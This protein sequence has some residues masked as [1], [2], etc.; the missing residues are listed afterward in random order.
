[1]KRSRLLYAGLLVAALAAWWTGD[2]LLG[3]SD[4]PSDP[5]GSARHR[6]M[7]PLT[8]ALADARARSAT[9]SWK[10][11]P[12]LDGGVTIS[13]AVIDARTHTGVGGVEV[14]FRSEAGEE[15]TTA[16]EDGAYRIDLPI[17]TYRAFVRDDTVLSIGRPDHVRLPGLPSADTAGVPDEA[18]MP[19]VVANADVEG[20]DLTVTRGGVVRGKVVDAAGRAIA[21]A[22]LRARTPGFRPALGTD[23][24][25]T[26][27]DGAFELRLPAGSYHLEVGHPRF[28]GVEGEEERLMI[29]PGDVVTRTF[30]LIAG[31]VIAGRV[32]GADGRATGDGAIEKQWGSSDI[33]FS[34]S[35]RIAPD[36]TFRWTTTEEI[37]VVLRAWPWK[38]P[39][40][41]SQ[42]FSCRDGARYD[43]VV[44]ALPNRGPDLDGVLVDRAGAPV[45]MAF[46]DLMPLDEG[47]IA[48]QER[49]DAQGRWSVFQLPAGRYR[50]MAHAPARGIVAT[51]IASPQTQVRLQLGGTGRI[52]GTASRL[53]K[54]SFELAFAVC[55]DDSGPIRLPV[56]RRLVTVTGG[57]FVVD[58]VPACDLQYVASWRGRPRPGRIEVAAGGTARIELD[59]GPPRAKVVHGTV[60]DAGRPVEGATV[61]AVHEDGPPVTA[62]TDAAGRYTLRTSL[63]ARIAAIK[64]N[65]SDG[66][67]RHGYAVAA[68]E[69][70]EPVDIAFTVTSSDGD[71]FEGPE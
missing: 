42:S 53:A 9:L 12:R 66:Q 37:E 14:V 39:P 29:E 49:T 20:V 32:V 7:S 15:T 44:F 1:M 6:S 41:P 10:P 71:V 48:Q 33:E 2:K 4:A 8:Q 16:G 36:G 35:G 13:G 40:S 31:C 38:A 3:G 69:D 21:N 23:V 60:T 59:L 17:G 43:H 61:T 34:P 28:A 22:V 5:A 19:I 56:E 18:L 24:A 63:G 26:G 67:T 25:E 58:D 30:T 65:P 62:T 46:I 55:Y 27:S 51:E 11:P 57:R 68:A 52:E 70:D 47:G 45:A 64:A 50:V 54:G